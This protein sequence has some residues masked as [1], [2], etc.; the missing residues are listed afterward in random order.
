MRGFAHKVWG[1][2]MV[3]SLFFVIPVVS[4]E[5]SQARGLNQEVARFDLPQSNTRREKGSPRTRLHKW[6][7]LKSPDG[8]FTLE[9][10]LKPSP[11]IGG[12]GPL[13]IIRS[14]SVTLNE[15]TRFSI[16]LQDI[17]GDPN[18]LE[19]NTWGPDLERLTST[20]DRE[21]GRRVIQVHRIATNIVEAEIL[22]TVAKSGNSIRYLRRSILRRARV[23]T[24]VCGSVV[25]DREIDRK[26]CDKF[27]NSL[28]FISESKTRIRQR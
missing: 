9:F 6:Y 4:D 13:T 16:N 28:R 2:T 20:A 21:D 19:N 5:R 15:A 23:Y 1:L 12:Q 18:A 7:T 3:L 25:D 10:P 8:E 17:G 11:E 27:F 26:P 14:F 24:L 22:Q